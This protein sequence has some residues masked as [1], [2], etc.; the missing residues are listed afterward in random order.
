MLKLIKLLQVVEFTLCEVKC[1]RSFSQS[2]KFISTIVVLYY[3][4]VFLQLY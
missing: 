2:F 1:G 3:N 4:I